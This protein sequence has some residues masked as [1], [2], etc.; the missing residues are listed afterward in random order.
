MVLTSMSKT[1]P[2]SF[3]SFVNSLALKHRLEFSNGGQ[4]TIL[5][6]TST[7]LLPMLLCITVP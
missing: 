4:F 3:K 1:K 2:A 5:M 7:N 6:L